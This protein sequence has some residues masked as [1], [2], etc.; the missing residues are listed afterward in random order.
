MYTDLS[1]LWHTNNGQTYVR[2][3]DYSAKQL[4]EL[5]LCAEKAA[6]VS[7]NEECCSLVSSKGDMWGDPWHPDASPVARLHAGPLLP[8]HL[9]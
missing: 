8:E 7:V 6:A 9:R 3:V 5:E 4:Q 2:F 1:Q